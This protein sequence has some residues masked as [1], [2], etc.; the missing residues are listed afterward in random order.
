V[1]DRTGDATGIT[2]HAPSGLPERVTNAQGG[3]STM[4]YKARVL[5]LPGVTDSAKALTFFDLA[6][7]TF[8]DGTSESFAYDANGN[9]LSRTDRAGK[10]WAFTFNGR[11]QALTATNPAGGV[12]TM[13]YDAAGNL[14]SSKDSATGA[15][16]YTYDTLNRLITITRPGGATV[17]FTSDARDLLLT[18]TDER[19]KTTSFGYDNNG[20]LISS[21]DA[22][23]NTAQIAYDVLDRVESFTDRLGKTS[24]RTFDARRLLASVTDRNGNATTFSYDERQRPTGI[25]DAGGQTWTLGFDDES[26]STSAA[27]P[28]NPPGRIKRNAMGRVVE[29]SNALGHTSAVVR[30][31]M[32]RVTQATDP[33]GRVT[34]FSYDKRGHLI[35]VSEEGG[36]AAKFTR[37]ALG[38]VTSI[39]APDGGIWKLSYTKE[40]RMHESTDPLGK[41]W[42]RTYD[43]R[44]RPATV[45][46]PDNVTQTFTYDNASNL[47]RAQFTGGPDLN[48]TYDNLNRPATSSDASTPGDSGVTFSYDEEGRLTG[49]L[50]NGIN[51]SATYD[52]GGRLRTVSYNGGAFVVT[53]SYDTRNRL[54]GVSDN[55]SGATISFTHDDAG[56]VATITRSNG[57][58]ATFTHDDAGRLT[59]IQDGTILDIKYARNA[60]GEVTAEERSALL[61]PGAAES[62]ETFAF[63]KAGQITTTGFTYDARGRLTAAP[64][65]TLAWDAA[66]RLITNGTTTN[67]YNAFGE[68]ITTTVAGATIRHFH[69]HAIGGSPIV[70]ELLETPG[71]IARYYVHTPGGALLYSVTPPNAN[72]IAYYHF[73]HLGST[74][75]L[76]NSAGTVTDSYAYG[77]FGEA[78]Q[79]TGPSTQPF[80]W[81]GALGVRKD[82]ALFQMRARWYDPKT[83]RF[84]SR[85]PL[86]PRLADVKS[87]NPYAYA[88]QNP[89]RYVDPMG[90][91]EG[92][93]PDW[94]NK[95]RGIGVGGNTTL[96]GSNGINIRTYV[97]SEL[98][99][100]LTFGF[101][102]VSVDPSEG[103]ESNS[104]NPFLTGLSNPYTIA[105]WQRGHLPAFLGLDVI[106][107]SC[108]GESSACSTATPL[109]IV[110]ENAAKFGGAVHSS[111]S[112]L[113]N[114]TAI[115]DEVSDFEANTATPLKSK[116]A[117]GTSSG[118][119]VV[120][121][122]QNINSV[123]P[124]ALLVNHLQAQPSPAGP[125]PGGRPRSSE[126]VDIL[127][128][129]N[130]INR[131][132]PA[133]W[134]INWHTP[135][136]TPN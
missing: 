13:T 18:T 108:A 8:P 47:T 91:Q 124:A 55:V 37:D 96:A 107:L 120:G 101:N 34:K 48:F 49:T 9:T 35:A 95:S 130:N 61:L 122:L 66:S 65:H 103:D 135:F 78:E 127:G 30:D 44:G 133:S 29:A 112:R 77:P 38:Q 63:G 98:G 19:G 28:V 109:E 69:H 16:G 85:D 136:T 62:S 40:G 33:L 79:H 23:T 110:R 111:A 12:S 129:M 60:A 100:Q 97:T 70:A 75:A 94:A 7:V 45:E 123:N 54:T 56:R 6:K 90:E 50:Q 25:T 117:A 72:A 52:N 86:P 59:R 87:L 11:G 105:Y 68:L 119:A 21:T 20:R 46:F 58:N 115:F 74:L 43:Q 80:T 17:T 39:A 106:T 88:N 114:W 3:T 31:A 82:G 134:L 24:S 53:Y 93:A 126:T 92:P 128:L 14:A 51:Y 84:L 10:T 131:I 76:S 125:P 27:N 15:T 36:G 71:T 73:D 89:L 41:I 42:H 57:V 102:I 5:K 83:A 32:Q 132:N 113:V 116:G 121:A 67:G 104:A 118:D 4:T 26:Q 64:G 81:L 1:V 99:L 2:Y 22:A